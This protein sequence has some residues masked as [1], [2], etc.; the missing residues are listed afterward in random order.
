[1]TTPPPTHRLE[2]ALSTE[3]CRKVR[4]DENFISYSEHSE[5]AEN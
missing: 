5:E 3:N 1:M 2:Q 4:K